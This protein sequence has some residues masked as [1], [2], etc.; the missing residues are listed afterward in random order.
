MKE[1]G[2]LQDQNS[3]LSPYERRKA[4]S[5]NMKHLYH[6]YR[7]NCVN[8]FSISIGDLKLFKQLI[9]FLKS[10]LD[11]PLH[12]SELWANPTNS[13]F[14]VSQCCDWCPGIAFM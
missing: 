11:S 1:M 12:I 4:D 8:I 13:L 2:Q 3:T 14:I 6:T 5:K 7:I 9:L 10:H